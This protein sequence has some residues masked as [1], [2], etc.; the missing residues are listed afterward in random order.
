MQ[1]FATGG[2]VSFSELLLPQQ[3]HLQPHPQFAQK[4]PDES[5]PRPTPQG[6]Q[7]PHPSQ[8]PTETTHAP[9]TQV[10][11]LFP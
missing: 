9:V 2:G 7:S 8:T 11:T 5:K 10:G 3:E 6:P 1:Q 4:H